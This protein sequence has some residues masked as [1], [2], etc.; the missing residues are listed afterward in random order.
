MLAYVPLHYYPCFSKQI[1][2]GHRMYEFYPFTDMPHLTVYNWY[3]SV[4]KEHIEACSLQ[5]GISIVSSFNWAPWWQRRRVQIPIVAQDGSPVMTTIITNRGRNFSMPPKREHEYDR[6]KFINIHT[7]QLSANISQRTYN[8]CN[9]RT[10][11]LAISRTKCKGK[12]QL[13]FSPVAT[14]SLQ[15]R[16]S[17]LT[18]IGFITYKSCNLDEA[19]KT[20]TA[21]VGRAVW[22]RGLKERVFSTIHLRTCG[23]HFW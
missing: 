22:E 4:K 18:S 15:I 3:Y 2:F 14:T 10:P 5:A 8:Q 12:R 21:T 13:R 20:A 7:S 11:D 23:S 19:C 6:E 1:W 16:W 9:D 17:A